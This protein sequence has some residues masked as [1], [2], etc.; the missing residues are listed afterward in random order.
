LKVLSDQRSKLN[1]QFEEEIKLLDSKIAAKKKP[2]F[3]ARKTIVSGENI[4]FED[5]V[6]KFDET[7]GSL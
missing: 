1:D 5:Y 4:Q 6:K 7:M 3:D 2:L